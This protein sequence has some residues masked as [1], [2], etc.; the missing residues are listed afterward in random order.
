MRPRAGDPSFE[1]HLLWAPFSYHRPGGAQGTGSGEQAAGHQSAA[2]L[3]VPSVVGSA[4]LGW[5]NHAP[6]NLSETQFVTTEIPISQQLRVKPR[7]CYYIS[8]TPPSCFLWLRDG[9]GARSA[10][11]ALAPSGLTLEPAV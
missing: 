8:R 9:T 3:L 10:Q 2:W 5:N 1:G 11:V 4:S 7:S 6:V